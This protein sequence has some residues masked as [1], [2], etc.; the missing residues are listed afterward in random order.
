MDTDV[1]VVANLDNYLSNHA[2]SGFEDDTH[3]PT[4]IMA[5]EKGFPLYKELL[6]YY[7]NRTFIKSDGSF[8]MV[9]NTMTITTMLKEKGLTLSG[10]RRI[11]II[12]P[13]CVLSV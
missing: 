4:G 3:I 13:R 8:D 12:S 1:E 11:C 2:F 6:D 10:N 5:C 7:T 9:S